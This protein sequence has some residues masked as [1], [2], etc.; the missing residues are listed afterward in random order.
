[1]TKN[2]LITA[3]LLLVVLA[4]AAPA[5]ASKDKVYVALSPFG[6]GTADVIQGKVPVNIA[7]STFFYLDINETMLITNVKAYPGYHLDSIV[8]GLDIS[9]NGEF[10]YKNY[11]GPHVGTITVYFHKDHIATP[12]PTPSPTPV[13]TPPPVFKNISIVLQPYGAGEA[14]IIRNGTSNET[15][16]NGTTFKVPVG[17]RIGLIAKPYKDFEF[18]ITIDGIDASL[19]EEYYHLVRD[20]DALM[21]VY[22]HSTIV[23][24]KP[25]DLDGSNGTNQSDM[26]LMLNI[27]LGDTVVNSSECDLNNNGVC[28]DAGDLTLMSQV[29]NGGLTLEPRR[30]STTVAP[31]SGIYWKDGELFAKIQDNT[32]ILGGNDTTGWFVKETLEKEIMNTRIE[33]TRYPGNNSWKLV[34]SFLKNSGELADG[35]ANVVIYGFGESVDSRIEKGGKTIRWQL[36]KIGYLHTVSSTRYIYTKSI[37]TNRNESLALYS[38]EIIL[39]D[40]EKFLQTEIPYLGITYLEASVMFMP[41]F[42]MIEFEG[43]VAKVATEKLTDIA[44]MSAKDFSKKFPIKGIDMSAVKDLPKVNA[45][46]NEKIVIDAA[47]RAKGEALWN[48]YHMAFASDKK[49]AAQKLIDFFREEINL[50]GNVKDIRYIEGD[51][52][53]VAHSSAAEEIVIDAKSPNSFWS[54]LDPEIGAGEVSIRFDYFS[55][56]ESFAQSRATFYRAVQNAEDLNGK[57]KIPHDIFNVRGY[58]AQ[59]EIL[60]EEAEATNSFGTAAKA[61]LSYLRTQDWIKMAQEWSE[62]TNQGTLGKVYMDMVEEIATGFFSRLIEFVK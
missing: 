35:D 51:I 59:T 28:G 17:E 11:G 15:I 36:S 21:T 38:V 46:R 37:D 53:R 2:V 9:L 55:L 30:P 27:S 19:N 32:Y 23:P 49:A 57:T 8:S 13:P 40:R 22:F 29:V 43:V 47:R 39:N 3:M 60:L 33:I 58:Q 6:A 26:D 42:A 5:A 18:D 12:T 14:K 10:W 20:S 41:D 61:T 1:M 44:M 16:V 52:P 25:G 62:I 45:F 31:D 56:D 34:K 50:P 24:S 54:F 4:I 48:E 7:Q